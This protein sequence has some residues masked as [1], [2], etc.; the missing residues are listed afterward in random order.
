M[1]IFLFNKNSENRR[2]KKRKLEEKIQTQTEKA[3]A[4][5]I[6]NDVAKVDYLNLTLSLL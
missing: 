3:K 5:A 2:L 1:L 6:I 4:D